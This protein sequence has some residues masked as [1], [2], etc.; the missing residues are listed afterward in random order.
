[1]AK[2]GDFYWR[3]TGLAQ[4]GFI[5]FDSYPFAFLLFI[6]SLLQL[7]FMFVIMVGQDVLGR[8][9][10]QRAQQTFLDGEAVLHECVR[11]QRHL[12]RAGPVIVTITAYVKEYAPADH[13]VMKAILPPRATI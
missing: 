12:T 4:L 8:A 7:V 9:G 3:L 6:S 5:K 10:D 2:T 11:L 13:P 1:M